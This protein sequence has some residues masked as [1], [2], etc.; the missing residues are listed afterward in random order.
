MAP[1]KR[2]C[3]SC[4]CSYR[5]CHSTAQCSKT[6]SLGFFF[7][8]SSMR[9]FIVAT[10][11]TDKILWLLNKRLR[12]EITK[13]RRLSPH[14]KNNK[15]FSK[16]R[17]YLFEPNKSGCWC[18]EVSSWWHFLFSRVPNEKENSNIWSPLAPSHDDH[19]NIKTSQGKGEWRNREKECTRTSKLEKKK[20]SPNIIPI[21]RW[22]P[23]LLTCMGYTLSLSVRQF[24][25]EYYIRTRRRVRGNVLQGRLWRVER[26]HRVVSIAECLVC[27]FFQV[28]RL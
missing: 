13:E 11:L 1:H 3:C 25:L 23:V 6:L 20:M 26:W 17:V 27:H 8:F 24:L 15:I 10:P 22:S 2:L 21:L 18:T 16:F 4:C 28:K 9:L 5:R 7:L 12:G 14:K 19:I